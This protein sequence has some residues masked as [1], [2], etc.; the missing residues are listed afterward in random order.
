MILSKTIE[1]GDTAKEF[2]PNDI[3]KAAFDE[4]YL[5]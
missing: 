1:P 3:Q 2:P 4:R 5:R